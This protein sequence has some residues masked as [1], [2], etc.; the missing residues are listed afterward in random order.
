MEIPSGPLKGKHIV[1]APRDVVGRYPK[2]VA[3][4]IAF[5]GHPEALVTDES[6]VAD[7][8]DGEELAAK[9]RGSY[10]VACEA[11]T[12]FSDL[13]PRICVGEEK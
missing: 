11:V 10:R 12:L 9:V 4:L 13:V 2:T 7:F 1:L 8:G 5:L 3:S 6:T